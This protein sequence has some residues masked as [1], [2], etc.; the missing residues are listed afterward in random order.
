MKIAI[1]YNLPFS[2]AKRAVF[3]HTKGLKKLG[4][5]VDVYTLD[6]EHDIF[7]PGSVA[8]NEYRYGYKQKIINLPFLKKITNDLSDF[9]LLKSVHRKIARD[10]DSMKYD[11]AL[12]HTD[13]YTQAPFLPRFLKAKNVYFCLEPLKIAYEYGLRISDNYSILN[14]EYEQFNRYIRKKIDRDNAIASD[15]IL[16]V[17]HF[18]R[19]L[20]IQAFDLYPKISYL[21]VHTKKFKKLS[22]P[23][24]NQVLFIG[25]KLKMNGYDYAQQAIKLI[26]PNIRPELKVLSISSDRSERIS[27]EEIVKLYNESILTLSLSKFDT[28][29]LVPL[30]SMACE[31]PVIAFNVAGDRETM[32]DGKT[33]F[34]VEFD[35]KEIA[36]KIMY[37]MNHPEEQIQMGKAGREWV[38]KNWTWD[39]QISNLETILKN[40]AGRKGKK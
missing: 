6:S 14:K 7:D 30:E 23:K 40:H 19:E 26:P 22:V 25:Q 24:K 35:P 12:V 38:E 33:G 21:G 29:G 8:D 10:I 1:F 9:Y 17:S 27:D 16:T 3:E 4:H 13:S 34:L 5:T 32:I 28:F 18:G 15:F 20:V 37:L 36:A 39:K 2:G 11:I 31:V